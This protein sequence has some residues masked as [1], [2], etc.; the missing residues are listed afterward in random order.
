MVVVVVVVV[1]PVVV[2]AAAVEVV[3]VMGAFGALVDLGALVPGALDDVSRAWRS[4]TRLPS[5]IAKQKARKIVAEENFMVNHP[6]RRTAKNKMCNRETQ[7]SLL[8]LEK[9]WQK[10]VLF[11]EASIKNRLL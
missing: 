1:V 3:V 11:R 6:R 9:V 7:G 5:T 8:R 10:I 2:V 4:R